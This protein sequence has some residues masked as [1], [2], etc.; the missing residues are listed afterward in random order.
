MEEDDVEE[1]GDVGRSADREVTSGDGQAE[2]PVPSVPA[3]AA[4]QIKPTEKALVQTSLH[5]MFGRGSAAGGRAG[6]GS[7]TGGSSAGAGCGA[8][9]M[10]K[11]PRQYSVGCKCFAVWET[12][13]GMDGTAQWCLRLTSPLQ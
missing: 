8:R 6:G 4:R 3:R 10:P 13:R 2:P 11:P 1:A 12:D 5:S 7:S 9:S